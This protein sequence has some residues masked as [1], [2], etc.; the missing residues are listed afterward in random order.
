MKKIAEILVIED[1]SG[2]SNQ[3][4]VQIQEV[5]SKIKNVDEVKISR[6]HVPIWTEDAENLSG[7]HV[8]VREVAE[9]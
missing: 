8:V 7:I 6:I 1:F 9:T 4:D 2:R 5:M 3:V